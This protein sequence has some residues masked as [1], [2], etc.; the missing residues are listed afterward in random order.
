M[1]DKKKICLVI[2]SLN[3]GGMERVMSELAGYFALK[4]ELEVHLIMY[5]MK[6]ELFYKIPTEIIIHKPS[7]LFNN[8]YRFWFT[9]KTLFFLRQEIKKVH[10]ES[11]LSFGEYWN[12]FVLLSLWRLNYRVFVS[13]RC[14]PGKSLGKMHDFLRKK[15]YVKAT[16]VIVQT[17]KAREIYQIMIPKAHIE[18]IGNPIREIAQDPTIKKE[19]IVLSVG[20]L[21]QSKYHDEL[22]KLFVEINAPGWKLVIVGGDALKQ[23]NW[24]RLNKLV[25]DLNANNRVVLTGTRNDVDYFY[26][27]SKIFAFASS[28]EGF[29]NV[30][31]E[32]LAAGIPAIAF[33]CIA[34]PS[35]LIKNEFNGYLIPLF[36]YQDFGEKLKRLIE[37]E[38]LRTTLAANAKK[39]IRPFMG[40]KILKN[41]EKLILSESS[42]N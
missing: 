25:S 41:F 36:N 19:N 4:P 29:P 6:P 9:I 14:Q 24:V 20:R 11:V 37:D 5:G 22:I 7:F 32:A 35:D 13:D 15:L 16:G 31:G 2:P 34:G 10:P 39:S 1:N 21:I 23:Q 8:K 28:S 18:V 30:I 17:E 27:K 12:S 26:R 42:T 33:D 40:E 38:Y 3:A